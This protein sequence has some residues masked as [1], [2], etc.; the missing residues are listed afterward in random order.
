MVRWLDRSTGILLALHSK[1]FPVTWQTGCAPAF[2]P[3][4]PV[5]VKSADLLDN[6]MIPPTQ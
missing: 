2:A 3:T 5:A 6:W 4:L 1:R